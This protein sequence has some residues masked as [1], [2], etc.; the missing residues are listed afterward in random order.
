[1]ADHV[2]DAGEIKKIWASSVWDACANIVFADIALARCLVE[3]FTMTVECLEIK[4]LRGFASEQCLQFARPTGQSGSGLTILVGPNSGGKSTVIESLDALSNRSPTFSEGKRNDIANRRVSIGITIDG[5]TTELRT[6]DGGGSQTVR[7]PAR[8]LPQFYVLP[9]RRFFPPYFGDGES[10]RNSYLQHSTLPSTRGQTLDRFSQRLFKALKDRDKFNEILK[11]V[12]DPA[13]EWTIDQSDQGGYYVSIDIGRNNHSSDGLG[14]GAISVLFLVDALYDSAPGDVIVIDEPELSLHPYYQQ[15]ISSLFAKYAS[16]RQI[17]YAT[18]SPYFVDFDNLL[19]GAEI[20]RI[21]KIGAS[22][23]ISQVS[24][25]SI[26]RLKAFHSDLNNPHVLGLSARETFFQDDGVI[27]LEGQEDVLHYQLVLEQLVEAGHLEREK[28][29]RMRECFF[30][31]GAGGASKVEIILH[32]MKDLGFQKVA[33]IFDNNEKA[34][35][36]GMEGLFPG[37]L[38][39]TIPADDIR[40][41][42]E[43]PAKMGI[44]GLLDGSRKIRPQHLEHT[45]CLFKRVGEFLSVP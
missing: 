27:V 36:R 35:I 15:R 26:G 4:G 25:S 28:L 24:R 9:S 1:M 5:K 43:R 44:E 39:A 20:A 8:P 18:H 30:G 22:S 17:V 45:K 32:L 31:W 33:A 23:Q 21:Y 38:I 41:K 37:F 2:T 3:S 16:D 42:P 40:T 19:N 7:E 12:I 6:V 13:P 34:R 14:D 10:D 29:S 11:Q